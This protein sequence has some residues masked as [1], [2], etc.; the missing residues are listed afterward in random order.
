MAILK[1]ARMGHPVLREKC[2]P[3]D[4]AK[5]TGPEVQRLIRTMPKVVICVVPGWA[6]GG[7]H[8][9]HVVCDLTVASAEHA[10]FKHT[11]GEV[12]SFGG[13]YATGRELVE[14]FMPSGAV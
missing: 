13:G 8:S 3:I 5:I 2:K 12:G 7:G 1:V 11:A 4:P 14:F 6:A 10:R 9:L